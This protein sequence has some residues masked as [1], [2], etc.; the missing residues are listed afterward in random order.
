ML[1]EK[2]LSELNKQ[3]NREFYSSY[4]YMGLATYFRKQNW[5]GFAHWMDVQ[6]KEEVEH[7]MKFYYYIFERGGVPEWDVV[8]K[9][10]SVWP[11]PLAAFQAALDHE[12]KITGHI[13]DLVR[14]A[15]E[16]SDYATEV[17]LQWFVM[18]QVEEEASVREIIQ[19]IN[20]APESL[21]HLFLLDRHLAQRKE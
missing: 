4:L 3:M 12:K 17:F 11:S 21:N 6:A 2:I 7:A 20:Q 15:R 10:P 9:P 1:S 16:E 14:L 19:H 18:E 13:N 8:E 5:N